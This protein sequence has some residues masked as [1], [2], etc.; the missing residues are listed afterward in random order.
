MTDDN[1]RNRKRGRGKIKIIKRQH[2]D[3]K[4]L[5]DE[6]MKFKKTIE[7]ESKGINALNFDAIKTSLG[8]NV[9]KFLYQKTAKRPIVI[10]VLLSI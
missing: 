2:V 5:G 4:E 10:P 3:N 8:D 7:D 6:L 1:Y 9:S